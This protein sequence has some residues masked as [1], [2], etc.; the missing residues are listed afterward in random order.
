LVRRWRK[1]KSGEEKR[2]LVQQEVAELIALLEHRRIGEL[3][4]GSRH[5]V[6]DSNAEAVTS[7]SGALSSGETETYE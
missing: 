1:D 5:A 7:V 4:L 2:T 3:R 6:L